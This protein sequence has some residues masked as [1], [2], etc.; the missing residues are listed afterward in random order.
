MG[1]SPMT[2][3]WGW[4]Y[5]ALNWRALS[6]W[7]CTVYMGNLLKY[8]IQKKAPRRWDYK[9]C[10]VTESLS[11]WS[12]TCYVHKTLRRKQIS[13]SGHTTTFFFFFLIF[14]IV[15]AVMLKETSL[16]RLL[17]NVV[18]LEILWYFFVFSSVDIKSLD[19]KVLFLEFAE[20][21]N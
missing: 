16:E 10:N 7:L 19:N 20:A 9:P 2:G 13:E 5:G 17:S 8:R 1:P 21:T 15:V 3:S 18:S 6:P 14:Y 11:V 12:S 4:D